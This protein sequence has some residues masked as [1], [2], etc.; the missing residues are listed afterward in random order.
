MRPENRGSPRFRWLGMRSFRFISTTVLAMLAIVV[1]TP[2][3]GGTGTLVA[4]L[5]HVVGL[6]PSPSQREAIRRYRRHRCTVHVQ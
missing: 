1:A 6:G 4:R 3:D 2:A 5:A